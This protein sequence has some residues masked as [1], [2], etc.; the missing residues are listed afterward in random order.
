M[1]IDVPRVGLFPGLLRLTPAC[2]PTPAVETA[3]DVI[4]V[5]ASLDGVGGRGAGGRV[6]RQHQVSLGRTSHRQERAI[7]CD[8]LE[9]ECIHGCAVQMARCA[10]FG[11]RFVDH[12]AAAAAT[13]KDGPRLHPREEVPAQRLLGLREERHQHADVV[14]LR[15]QVF[16]RG[17]PDIQLAFGFGRQRIA[18]VVE[19]LAAEPLQPPRQLGADLAEAENTHCDAPQ[20]SDVLPPAPVVSEV[21]LV[22]PLG[23][24]AIVVGAQSDIHRLAQ[25]LG[26]RQHLEHHVFG[27]ADATQHRQITH[28]NSRG[29]R[30]RQVDIVRLRAEPL[31]H[32]QVFAR[33]DDVRVDFPRA[34]GDQEFLAGQERQD[35]LLG[36]RTHHRDLEFSRRGSQ[37][38]LLVPLPAM[39]DE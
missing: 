37:R 35:L 13:D 15:H 12:D 22:A 26:A 28:R 4:V 34:L 6:R 19:D 30:R 17:E 8:R 29:T 20:P 10:G 24:L 36:R 7:C 33:P 25:L 3:H 23:R 32:P 11:E 21:V 16:G 2:R 5:L 9:G 38:S 14:A 1:F 31:D 27:H 39:R 18:L